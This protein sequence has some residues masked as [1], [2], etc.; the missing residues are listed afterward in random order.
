MSGT[1]IVEHMA[2]NGLQQHLYAEPVTV[3]ECTRPG[4]SCWSDT[5]CCP[6]AHCEWWTCK[7]R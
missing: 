3:A 7:R 4:G 2:G 1:S 6:W 5:D